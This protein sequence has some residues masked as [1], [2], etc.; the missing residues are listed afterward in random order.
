MKI[1]DPDIIKNGENDL[2]EAVKDDLD[3]DAVKEILKKRMEA[4]KL[5]SKGGEIIVHNNEIAYRLDFDIH[6]SGSLMFDR[7]GNYISE[8]DQT[9]DDEPGEQE[10]PG[11]SDDQENLISE[12][13]DLEDI[14]IDET[15][16]EVAP[17]TLLNDDEDTEI[18]NIETPEEEELNIA[19]PDYNLDDELD[20][21]NGNPDENENEPDVEVGAQKDDLIEND[22]GEDDDMSDIL[23]ESRDFWDQKKDS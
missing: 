2:I 16:E 7:Q 11:K 1:T 19:L 17:Q 8:S 5:S 21:E 3:L 20:P 9:V 13:F 18:E 23:Q 15:L 4:A 10:A 6:L 12:D 14:N 22:I